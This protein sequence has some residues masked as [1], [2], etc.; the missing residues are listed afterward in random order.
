MKTSPSEVLKSHFEQMKEVIPEIYEHNDMLEGKDQKL[1]ALMKRTLTVIDAVYFQNRDMFTPTRA[2]EYANIIKE[3]RGMGY[4]YNGNSDLME[5]A[6]AAALMNAKLPMEKAK[7]SKKSS[8]DKEEK[9]A[10]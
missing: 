1:F 2:E 10:G 5:K 9:K 4:D 8:V 6:T 3:L 7:G